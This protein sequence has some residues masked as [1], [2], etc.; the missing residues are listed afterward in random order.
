MKISNKQVMAICNKLNEEFDE[1]KFLSMGEHNES[2]LLKT[3]SKKLVLRIE[4][5]LQYKNLK[6]EYKFLKLINGKFAPKVFLFDNSHKIIN[7]DYL[8]EEFIEGKHPERNVDNRFIKLMA[9]WYKKLHLNKK[10]ISSK[11]RKDKNLYNQLVKYDKNSNKYKSEVSKEIGI[12]YE[13][14][15][16]Q[17]RLFFQKYD[18]LLNRRKYFV[19]VH[20]DST[21]SNVFY[22]KM[23]V[24]LIDWE[25]V[26]YDYSETD[27]VFFFYS[28][29]LSKKQWRLFLDTYGYKNTDISN[30]IL[31]LFSMDHYIGMIN[32]RFER[33][34]FISTGKA[35]LRQ[36]SSNKNK[37]ITGIKEELLKIKQ[38][39]EHLY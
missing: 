34:H 10:L 15:I 2:Y 39:L 12:L 4:N 25:F 6:K 28:Y 36:N 37:M 32:W 9:Q 30:K 16:N 1:L 27:L 33:L 22:D 19:M 13:S 3:K 31:D 5:N 20:G 18:K 24:K 38:I 14:V 11:D 29:D 23:S 17:T 26:R 21:K 35:D 7:K 8:I